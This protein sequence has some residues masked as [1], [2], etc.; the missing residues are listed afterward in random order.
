MTIRIDVVYVSVGYL[1]LTHPGVLN[2][3]VDHAVI[4][5]NPFHRPE[6]V[7]VHKLFDKLP[8]LAKVFRHV[9]L[10]EKMV[11]INWLT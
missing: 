1:C 11:H 3:H 7:C 4:A 9:Q 2:L 6:E 5:V 8:I 10:F